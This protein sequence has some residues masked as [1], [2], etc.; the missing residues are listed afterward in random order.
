MNIDT[1]TFRARSAALMLVLVTGALT[2]A[3]CDNKTSNEAT[4]TTASASRITDANV[5]EKIEQARTPADHE[6]LAVYYDE[7]AQAAQREGAD[8][9]ELRGRYERR[10]QPD[11]HPMGPGARGHVEGLIESHEQGAGHYRSMADWHR[12]MAQSAQQSPS[13][14][15]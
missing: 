2:L 3:G 7:R 6:E 5:A 14:D 9:R 11:S 15:E 1:L 4:S 8:E 12:Q 13:T 10:W